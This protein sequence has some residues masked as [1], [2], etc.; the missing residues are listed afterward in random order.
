M[1]QEF[2]TSPFIVALWAGWIYWFVWA[3]FDGVRAALEEQEKEKE[4]ADG[5]AEPA[6]A[7]ERAAAPEPEAG[8]A[9]E[10]AAIICELIRREGPSAPEAFLAEAL[11]AYEKVVAAFNSGD[12]DALRGLVSDE[13]EAAFAE[14]IAARGAAGEVPGKVLSGVAPPEI[15]GGV[16]DSARMRISVRF[17][18]ESFRPSGAAAPEGPGGRR[19]RRLRTVD[20]WTFERLSGAGWQVIATE[21]GN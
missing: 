13:V 15:V 21:A 3:W 2:D 6:A 16:L 17:I 14:A 18:G 12:R 19:A 4:K 10:R 20:I 8:L 9:P 5:P 7:D 1:S 11:A